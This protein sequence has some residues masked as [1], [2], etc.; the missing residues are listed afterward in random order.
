M[1]P[2][3]AIRAR[4]NDAGCKPRGNTAR[5][6]AHDDRHASLSIGVGQDGRA[7]LN[8]HAGCSLDAVLAKLGL[9]EADLFP[10]RDTTP[11]NG[12]QIVAT[13]P[14]RDE[15]G[16]LLYEVVRYHPK[17]FRQRK[18][19]A[20][21]GYDWSLNGVRR[22]PYRLAEVRD[23]INNKRRVV[24]VEGERDADRLA[25]LG[26][27]ATTNAGGA[28][29]WRDD[30]VTY[31]A[32]GHVAIIG[33]ND[34]PGREWTQAVT[35]S[36]Q[37]I[38]ADIRVVN[39]EGLPEHGDVSDWLDNGYQADDLKAA[40]AMTPP[41]TAATTPPPESLI[42][43][44]QFW[45]TDHNAEDFTVEPLLPRGRSVAMYAPAG[46]GKSLLGADVAARI[47]TGQH[48]LDQPA[49]PP[50][51]VVYI[52]AEMTEG[53]LQERLTDMGYGPNTDLTHLHY[54][55]LPELPPLD[56]PEGGQ[57][58]RRIAAH[59]D[60]TLVI[61]DTIGRVVDGPEN[62][63]DTWRDF[64]RHTGQLLK[65]DDR[66]VWRLDHAGKDLTKGQRGSSA[67]YDDV[68]IVWELQQRE[69][70]NIRLIARKRRIAWVPEQLDLIRLDN[71]LRHERAQTT[72]PNG[73]AELAATLNRLN[74]PLDHGRGKARDTLTANNIKATNDVLTAAIRWR[75]QE[76]S[77]GLS[78]L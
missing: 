31:F 30:Y 28:K 78:A 37:D 64:H 11:S 1:T 35:A 41:A 51:H 60:A 39:L 49:G 74:I 20:G 67:K 33:D 44:Q 25:A 40:I 59:H 61:I 77:H 14:Y 27:T 13:Y 58:L 32:G 62:D 42:D 56:T 71:P 17:D 69:A 18:P 3:D 47:A 23:A 38:A 50:K 2:T 76:H 43:W 10:P 34:A 68:D 7:L 16:Q 54:Y 66:T 8:C 9:T 29:G 15:Q 55:L 72:W 36:L 70:A 65:A 75:R 45:Q 53:D 46:K 57:E 48:C 19:K 63:A 5:C 6:P 12:K 26:I 22:V 21:G 24:I 4:L 52:D 73:T